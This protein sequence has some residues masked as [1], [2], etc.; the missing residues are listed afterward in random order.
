MLVG[1]LVRWSVYPLA[2]PHI[3]SKTSYVMIA[4]RRG[5]GRENRLMSK[6]DYVEIASRLV[7]VAR[8]CFLMFLYFLSGSFVFLSYDFFMFP[9]YSKQFF[10][11]SSLFSMCFPFK[12]CW[13][14]KRKICFQNL[15]SK[16]FSREDFFLRHFFSQKFFPMI[17]VV[18]QRTN[19]NEFKQNAFFMKFKG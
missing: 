8:S 14:K 18:C 11:F 7:T 15:F 2:G 12:T 9:S 3:T 19:S 10:S 1:W 16:F 4:S 6:T 5:E 17:F 13:L